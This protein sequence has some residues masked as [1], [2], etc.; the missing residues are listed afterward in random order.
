[1]KISRK[2]KLTAGVFLAATSLALA[3]WI[4]VPAA[5][6]SPADNEAEAPLD[7]PLEIAVSPLASIVKFT[8][9]ADGQLLGM[10]YNLDPGDLVRSYDLK[11]GQEVRIEAKVSSLLGITR[12][13]VS[14]FTTVAPMTVQSI[15][16]NGARLVP[17]Q[18]IPPQPTLTFVFNKPVSQASVTVDGGGPIDLQ[19]DAGNPAEAILPPT[20]S[21]KQ[22]GAHILALTAAGADSSTISQDMR[23]LVIKPLTLYGKASEAEGMT[24]VELDASVAFLDP[25]AIG[26]VITTTLPGASVKVEKQ[27]VIITSAGLERSGSYSISLPA[28]EGVDGSFLERPLT[29]TLAYQADQVQAVSTGGASGYTLRYVSS[30]GGSGGQAGSP[31]ADATSSSGPPPG[32]PDCCP[33]PPQ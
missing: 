2:M 8:V 15:S 33:W 9:Y 28:A 21:F 24:R 4:S 30:G 22:G 19:V 10:E 17:G 31:G 20:V 5:A 23:L 18:K 29:L 25:A 14:S 32:W 13:F 6:I 26:Q 11:P 12:E 16:V 3:G 1:M 27:K 7:R